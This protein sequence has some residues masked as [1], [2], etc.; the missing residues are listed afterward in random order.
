M[1][2]ALSGTAVATLKL[3]PSHEII[4]AMGGFTPG[5]NLDV[6]T[7]KLEPD[8]DRIVTGYSDK[9]FT[10]TPGKILS[11]NTFTPIIL[12]SQL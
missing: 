1:P 9:I 6:P 7:N 11:A 10:W 3:K 12:L 2:A 5:S 8:N 4:V